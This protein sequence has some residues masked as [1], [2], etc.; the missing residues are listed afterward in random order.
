MSNEWEKKV[1]GRNVQTHLSPFVGR[2]AG[3]YSRYLPFFTYEGT[4]LSIATTSAE[5][6]FELSKNVA[7]RDQN[8]Q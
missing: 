3:L 8:A 1:D 5:L 7:T 4:S 2:P 6:S